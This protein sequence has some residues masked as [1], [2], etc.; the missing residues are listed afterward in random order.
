MDGEDGAGRKCSPVGRGPAI[1]SQGDCPE[2]VP[3]NE[4]E[5]KKGQVAQKQEKKNEKMS[6]EEAQRWL[7][8]LKE[9]RKKQFK[10]QRAQGHGQYQV[11]KD[12]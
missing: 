8:T 6:K 4:K 3:K 5:Q 10:G 1:F 11:E 9:K 2:H 7:S 12:W